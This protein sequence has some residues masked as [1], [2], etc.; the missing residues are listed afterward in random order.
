MHDLE[1]TGMFE[2]FQIAEPLFVGQIHECQQFRLTI[3]GE[4]Y[5]GIYKDDEINW[6]HPK[7]TTINRVA[8]EV[9]VYGLIN[10]YLQ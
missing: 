3:N 10:H 8:I 2:N 7:P 5:K 4:E 1:A 6:Y 9:K